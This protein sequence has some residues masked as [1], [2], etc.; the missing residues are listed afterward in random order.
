[1]YQKVFMLLIYDI[2]VIPKLV[3]CGV[4]ARIGTKI[5]T[6]TFICKHSLCCFDYLN[7]KESSVTY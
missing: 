7:T 1:M 6:K 5:S 4:N 2:H 3:V